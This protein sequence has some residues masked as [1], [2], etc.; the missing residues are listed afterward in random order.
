M[1]RSSL[2]ACAVLV[3]ATGLNAACGQRGPLTL[4]N[5]PA[6]MAKPDGA[7]TAKPASAGPAASS[8]TQP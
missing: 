6:P 7:T 4:P 3:L 5:P 8:S 2:Y 1:K